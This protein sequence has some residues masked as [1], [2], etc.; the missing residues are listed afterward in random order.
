MMSF[1]PPSVE[2]WMSGS[3]ALARRHYLA[4]CSVAVAVRRITLCPIRTAS[5]YEQEL[6]RP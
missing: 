2:A 1:K 3:D 5:S 4:L 6:G